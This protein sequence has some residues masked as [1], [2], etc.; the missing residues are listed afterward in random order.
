[1][2]WIKQEDCVGCETC[3]EE[4]P[5]DAIYLENETAHIEKKLC[6]RCGT[7]HD[8][9]PEEAIR[10]DGE[11]IPEDVEANIEWTKKLLKNYSTTEE[12]RAFLVRIG[13]YF[14]KEKVVAEKTIEQIELLKGQL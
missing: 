10:H 7:C 2:P 13:K 9:C 8:I 11:K 3:I 6:I 5:V 1:M 14:N 4:C 12:R